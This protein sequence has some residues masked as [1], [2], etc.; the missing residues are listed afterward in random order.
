QD[1]CLRAKLFEER[2]ALLVCEFI[3]DLEALEGNLGSK[4]LMVGAVHD[5]EAAFGDDVPHLVSARHDLS[6]DTEA[7]FSHQNSP[8]QNPSDSDSTRIEREPNPGTVETGHA[9]HPPTSA[10]IEHQEFPG[11]GE[12]ISPPSSSEPP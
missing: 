9:G 1:F 2:L 12:N 11:S 10:H 4:A 3:G 5:A 7:V 8:P 6:D